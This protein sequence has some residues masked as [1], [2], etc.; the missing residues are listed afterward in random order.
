MATFKIVNPI[1][2]NFLFKIQCSIIFHSNIN[3]FWHLLA[4]LSRYIDAF[5]FSNLPDSV[6]AVGSRDRGTPGYWGRFWDLNRNL[7][8]NLTVDSL[9]VG[10]MMWLSRSLSLSVASITSV[11]LGTMLKKYKELS[12]NNHVLLV[13]FSVYHVLNGLNLLF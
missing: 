8:A 13:R 10:A 6:N 5:S 11:W 1:W 3:L 4:V 7:V 9:A 12:A 2:N